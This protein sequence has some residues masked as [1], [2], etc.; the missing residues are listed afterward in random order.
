[1]QEPKRKVMG[2]YGEGG[3][4]NWLLHHM[5][6]YGHLDSSAQRIRRRLI[7]ML[8]VLKAKDDQVMEARIEAV[9]GTVSRSLNRH[10]EIQAL[11]RE[12]DH[13]KANHDSQVKVN[14]LLRDRPDMGERARLVALLMQENDELR[15]RLQPG[16]ST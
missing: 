7:R 12:R 2:G 6:Y 13:W 1:M 8:K 10:D 4:P 11:K 9:R 3:I 15:A 14:R 16:S 5:K